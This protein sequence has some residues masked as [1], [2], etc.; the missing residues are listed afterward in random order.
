MVGSVFKLKLT[1]VCLRLVT[2]WVAVL[3]ITAVQR[4]I[5]LAVKTELSAWERR[6]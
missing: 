6:V 2:H 1:A 4:R 3:G 5:T